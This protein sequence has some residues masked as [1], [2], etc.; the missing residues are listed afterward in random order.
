[1]KPVIYDIEVQDKDGFWWCFDSIEGL[2]EA[3]ERAQAER[4]EYP[5]DG[6]IRIKRRIDTP[7]VGAKVW[8]RPTQPDAF[9][10]F[11]Y[12]SEVVGTVTETGLSKDMFTWIRVKPNFGSWRE[13][14]ILMRDFK[15]R[16][17]REYGVT[18]N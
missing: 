3:K 13:E 18:N 6:P 9:Q 16:G 2:E 14:R 10:G 1:M 8:Y 11:S 5:H 17:V 7:E 4:E 12:P 15:K